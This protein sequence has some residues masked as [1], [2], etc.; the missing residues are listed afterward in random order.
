MISEGIVAIIF[1]MMLFNSSVDEAPIDFDENSYHKCFYY[2]INSTS[3]STLWI[4]GSI[5][6][7][8]QI[9]LDEDLNLGLKEFLL[10]GVN[11]D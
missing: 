7:C 8:N 5:D 6:S 10:I 4:Y 11:N 2:D 9:G 1:V 3:V